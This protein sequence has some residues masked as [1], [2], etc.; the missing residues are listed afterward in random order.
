[1]AAP[2]SSPEPDLP[3]VTNLSAEASCLTIMPLVPQMAHD[4]VAVEVASQYFFCF[5]L[6]SVIFH[7]VKEGSNMKGNNQQK[8]LSLTD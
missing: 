6:F 5:V 8:Q 4:Y 3:P 2:A 1:M 7:A